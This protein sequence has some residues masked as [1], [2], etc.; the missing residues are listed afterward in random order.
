MFRRS[1]EGTNGRGEPV[2]TSQMMLVEEAGSGSDWSWREVDVDCCRALSSGSV[3]WV[4]A[5][6]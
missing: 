6:N 1:E 3:C 5:N 2:L 4:C